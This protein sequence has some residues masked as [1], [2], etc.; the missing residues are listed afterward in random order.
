MILQQNQNHK[1]MN[2]LI[3]NLKKKNKMMNYIDAIVESGYCK[4]INKTIYNA[5]KYGII[6][7]DDPDFNEYRGLVFGNCLV[8]AGL[9]NYWIS[10][11]ILHQKPKPTILEHLGINLA[12]Q[13]EL[14]LDVFYEYIDFVQ[15]PDYTVQNVQHVERDI[16]ELMN[17]QFIQYHSSTK[18][19]I[20]SDI[21]T[22]LVQL[23][24]EFYEMKRDYDAVKASNFQKKSEKLFLKYKD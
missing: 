12:Q 10:P 11:I 20:L 22:R 3:K 24:K 13:F 21:N 7:Y 2:C 19:L 15:D 1:K 16:K 4:V 8:Q 18:E 14:I 5:L 9:K 23:E 17:C 6:K